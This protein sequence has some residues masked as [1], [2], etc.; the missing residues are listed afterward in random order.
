MSRPSPL[1]PLAAL[2]LLLAAAPATALPV[3]FKAFDGTI[4]NNSGRAP[5]NLVLTLYIRCWKNAPLNP[6]GDGYTSCGSKDVPVQITGSSGNKLETVFSP[7][8]R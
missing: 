1:A 6:W 4:I 7:N 8:L 5:S 2:A 3:K